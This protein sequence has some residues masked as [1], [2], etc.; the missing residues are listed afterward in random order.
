[1]AGTHWQ[2]P[3]EAER[4]SARPGYAASTCPSDIRLFKYD[5]M[6]RFTRTSV[7]AVIFVWLPVSCAALVFGARELQM[8][9]GAVAGYIVAGISAWTLVEYMLHRFVFHLDRWIPASGKLCFLI[10]GCHHADPTDASRDIMPPAGSA[11]LMGMA[12]AVSICLLGLAGGLLFFGGFSIAYL[13]YDVTHYGCHQWQ[14]PG[15]LGGY[16]RRYHLLHH[17]RDEERHFGVTSPFWD[18]IFGTLRLRQGHG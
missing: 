2:P 1:M 9:Y 3:E 5:F 4:K 13:V 15:R 12:L 7:T 6:E 10:H 11:P 17:Y 18:W 14:L 16:L 8:S